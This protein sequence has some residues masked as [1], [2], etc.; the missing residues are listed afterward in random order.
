[1]RREIHEEAG[2]D[3]EELK[4]RGTISWPGFGK[5]GEDWLGFV[6]VVTRFSGTPFASN[7]K[8]RWN[9]CR[10]IAWMSCRCGKVTATSCRW[11]STRPARVPRR[12]AV[13]RRQDGVV[14]VLACVSATPIDCS[15]ARSVASDAR[16]RY[17]MFTAYGALSTKPYWAY[18]CLASPLATS[19][20]TDDTG[21]FA[22]S[23][24]SS[25]AMMRLPRPRP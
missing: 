18:R 19:D 22:R 12:D 13:S 14:G 9:G 23:Q 17:S 4:L 16:T 5:H 6:F 1:M 25:A 10:W 24:A 15:V 11:C 21:A 2:I 7:R 8:A 3:C 20:T